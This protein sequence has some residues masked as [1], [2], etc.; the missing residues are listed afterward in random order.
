MG[1]GKSIL[2]NDTIKNSSSEPEE[3][4]QHD[5]LDVPKDV[6]DQLTVEQKRELSQL[7]KIGS[8]SAHKRGEQNG[9]TPIQ[10]DYKIKELTKCI[11]QGKTP[12]ECHKC[13]KKKAYM[14]HQFGKRGGTKKLYCCGSCFFT[15]SDFYCAEEDYDFLS[16]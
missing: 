15:W 16:G 10:V 14:Y 1:G 12:V 4:H 13:K 8:K 7:P 6:E 11:V 2:F 3:Q 5:S 9:L